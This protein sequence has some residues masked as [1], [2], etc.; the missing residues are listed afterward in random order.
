R[1]SPTFS[2]SVLTGGNLHFTS[3]GGGTS[4]VVGFHYVAGNT[5]LEGNS[6]VHL[7]GALYTDS[8][9]IGHTAA[10]GLT[11]TA[12]PNLWADMTPGIPERAVLVKQRP[13]R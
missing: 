12:D 11:I 6:H 5:I 4:D 8:G 13:L 3:T 10:Q 9:L 7:R 2:V 1:S